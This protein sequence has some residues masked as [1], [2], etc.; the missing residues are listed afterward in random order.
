MLASGDGKE[1]VQTLE[2]AF[3]AEVK[4][5][6]A[7]GVQFRVPNWPILQ[8]LIMEKKRTPGDE[9]VVITHYPQESLSWCS[10]EGL[11]NN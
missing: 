3:L 7:S 6:S 8:G 11:G 9:V 1:R 2:M 4:K 5:V 10:L